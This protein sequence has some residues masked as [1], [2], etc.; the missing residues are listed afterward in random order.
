MKRWSPWLLP[1]AA[2]GGLTKLIAT[3]PSE[4]V[5]P[6][7]IRLGTALLLIYAAA[8]LMFGPSRCLALAAIPALWIGA[9]ARFM[10][11][12]AF[13]CYPACTT[14]QEVLKWCLTVLGY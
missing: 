10:R 3:A 12:N 11:A 4:W 14:Y 9:F 1:A 6:T 7:T 8:T 5:E 13:D 2:Y